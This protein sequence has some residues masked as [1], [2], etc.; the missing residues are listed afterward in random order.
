MIYDILETKLQ[1]IGLEPGKSLFR[2]YMPADCSV[3]V[4]TRV[5][6]QGLPIDPNIPNFYRGRMQV[7]TRHKD[8]VAGNLMAARVQSV[9]EM[10]AGR[11]LHGANEERGDVHLDLFQPETLPISFPRLDGNG[12][13]WSQMFLCAFGMK[14]I[15]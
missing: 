2:N 10:R 15:A 11:E 14:P 7:I 13:E 8:P 4:M 3:G 1:A 6:L 9:L 5:P 12:F